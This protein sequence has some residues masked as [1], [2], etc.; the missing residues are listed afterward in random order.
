MPRYAVAG[1]GLMGRVVARDLLQSEPDA[2]ITLFDNS[3]ALLAAAAA[4]IADARLATRTLDVRDAVAASAALAGH[5]VVLG[6]LPHARSLDLIDAAIRARVSIVDLVGSRPEARLGR[7]ASAR[8]AGVLVV[9]GCGV[10]PGLSNVLVA[11]GIDLLDETDDA[12]IYVGGVPRK[13][14]PPLDYQTVYRLESMFNACVRPARIAVGGRETFVEPLSGLEHLTFP[15]P[16]GTLEAFYTDGLASL[17][18]TLGHRVRGSL[19]EKTLRYPGFA[20][21]IGFLKACGLLEPTPVRIGSA[22]VVPMELVIEQLAPRLALGPE[23]DILAMRVIVTGRKHGAPRRHR[24]DL[25]DFFDARTGYTAMARTTGFPA[26]S[27][28][29][30]IAAGA[31]TERGVRFPE[32]IFTGPRYDRLIADLAARGVV[33]TQVVE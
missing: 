25:I 11:R 27:A 4:F 8:D 30:L 14:G 10:A 15:D 24:F 7:D 3:D 26:T 23:G 12:I 17:A 28:A 29:R 32:Q 20:E 1:A 21:K 33:V 2:S 13:K 9:P 18:L 5:D 19:V 6:A 16:I 31:P 22:E